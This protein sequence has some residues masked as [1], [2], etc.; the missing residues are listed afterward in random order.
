MFAVVREWDGIEAVFS[1]IAKAEAYIAKAKA[2]YPGA[3]FSI[4]SIEID[5]EY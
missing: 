3:E 4:E 5:P 2:D 1:S